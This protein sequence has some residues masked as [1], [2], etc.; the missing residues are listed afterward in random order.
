MAMAIII[1]C[2]FDGFGDTYLGG[3]LVII[4]IETHCKEVMSQ[5]LFLSCIF[6]GCVSEIYLCGQSRPFSVCFYPQSLQ[7]PLFFL[8]FFL[9][10]VPFGTLSL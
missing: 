2:C 3:S 1:V 5:A 8:R 4:T 6:A 9:W 10:L 7:R